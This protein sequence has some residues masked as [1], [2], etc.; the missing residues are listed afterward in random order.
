MGERFNPTVLKTVESQGSVGSN[1]T[2][3]AILRSYIMDQNL[4][5]YVKVYKS[6]ISKDICES[7][8]EDLEK[9][10][11]KKHT[12]QNIVTNTFM[13]N[14]DDLSVFTDLNNQIEN[15][16][17][18]LKISGKIF[19]TYIEDLS[20]SWWGKIQGYV[21]IR[22]NKY[23]ENTLMRNHCDHIHSMFDGSRKGIPVLSLVGL[24]NDDFEGGDFIMF[25]DEKIPQGTGDIIVF[26]SV[27]LYPHRVSRITKGTRYS[28]VTWAV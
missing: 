28:Y 11:F 18:I 23:D 7:T 8:I 20:F 19:R 13:S 1:P 14:D 21:P 25:D 6:V 12:Y 9:A 27:F 15:D 17:D 10:E 4:S 26:P 3:S 16:A 22:Y 2:A 24:L 5:S